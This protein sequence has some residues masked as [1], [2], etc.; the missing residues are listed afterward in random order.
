MRKFTLIC[1]ATLLSLSLVACSDDSNPTDTGTDPQVDEASSKK[2]FVWNAMNYWYFWVG[3]V[4]ELQEDYFES[5]QDLQNYLKDFSDAE[6]LFNELIY[7]QADDF[8]FFIE[9]YEEFQQSQ[10]GISMS[11]GYQFGLVR[12]SESSNELFGYV[13]YVVSGSPADQSGLTRGDIFTSVNGTQLTAENYQ[14]LLRNTDSY[15]LTLAEIQNDTISATGNT[16]TLQAESL[17]ENPVY[18]SKVIQ[19]GSVNIGYLKYNAFQRNSHQNLNEVFA[20]FQSEGINELVVDLRYN[21]GGAGITSQMLAG[22]ISGRDSTNEFA[23]YSY[24][25]K[26]ASLWNRSVSIL[27]EVPLF[28]D[29]E[30]T[31]EVPMNQLSLDRVYFLVGHGTASASELLI[32]GLKP[33]M[34]VILIGQQTVGKD[35]GSYTLYDAP[36]PYLREEDANPEHKI[37]IQPIVLKLVNANGEGYPNGFIPEYTLSEVSYLSDGLP[38]LGDESEPLLARALE[39]ITGESSAKRVPENATRFSPGE[40]LFDSNDLSR[41][42]KQLYLQPPALPHKK[43]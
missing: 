37:A 15:E 4:P 3:D 24:N 21:G 23:T 25:D 8:S 5:N 28:E 27:S 13:Q 31:S 29:G 9:D 39:L 7:E 19:E 2:Q 6:A 22:M 35:E 33:Y 1:L 11:F 42:K 34:E 40:I 14:D 30:K 32:N 10:Q 36:E 16:V 26:R 17:Q 12:I 18:V 38:P 41:Y 43:Q 20:N